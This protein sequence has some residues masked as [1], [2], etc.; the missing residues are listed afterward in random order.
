MAKIQD[1]SRTDLHFA[2]CGDFNTDSKRVSSAFA[3][4]EALGF[5]RQINSETT[6]PGCLPS[7]GSLS[8]SN[9][10]DN[11]LVKNVS[12]AD[13]GRINLVDDINNNTHKL[14]VTYSHYILNIADALWVYKDSVS[15][16]LPVACFIS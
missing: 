16:H 7:F 10:Y 5:K 4:L 15:D 12:I 14:K 11:I 6:T 13:R 3:P 8:Y 2:V 1:L 9:P